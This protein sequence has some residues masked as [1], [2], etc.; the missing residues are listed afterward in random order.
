MEAVS[1]V[2]PCTTSEAVVMV[3]RTTEGCLGTV[4]WRRDQIKQMYEGT[5][6]LPKPEEL[7]LVAFL[8]D[9]HEV[10]SLEEGELGETSLM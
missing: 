9:H 4:E 10:F 3:R 1:V 7:K 8:A 2:D 6:S 5:F